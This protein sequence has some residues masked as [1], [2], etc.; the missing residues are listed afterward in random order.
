[1]AEM[2][3]DGKMQ[4]AYIDYAESVIVS[5]TY[6]YE[7]NP[8]SF[9]NNGV[10]MVSATQMAKPFGRLVGDWLRLKSTEEFV[11]ALSSDMQIPISALIQVVKG[12]NGEQGTW[13]HEDV[14][15]EFARW[16]S[17]KFAIWCNRRIKELVHVGFTATPA[18]LEAMIANPDLVIGMATQLKQLRAENEEKQKLIS[19]QDETIRVQEDRIEKMLPK[20]S[21]VDQILQSPCTVEVTTIA[22]DYGMTARAFNKLLYSLKIQYRVGKRWILYNPHLGKG[23]V[24]SA[25][26]PMEK[27]ASGRTYTYT[28]WTQRGRLFLYEELKRNNILP[29]IEQCA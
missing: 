12:G 26:N 20:V 22:Q 8:V 7:G 16:L 23:Y 11:N 24:Q 2:A 17:P 19:A 29:T 13:I 6:N 10:I 3:I 18:T 5:K 15:L 28:R 1:M 9:S 14:A 4:R 21:Y 27:S 25:T